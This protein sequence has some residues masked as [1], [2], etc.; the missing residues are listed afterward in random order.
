VTVVLT[1]NATSRLTSDL[2]CLAV[3]D[4]FDRVV[5]SSEIGCIKPEPE[6]FLH[7]I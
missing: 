1:T 6:Y 4:Y 3:T 5:N 2:N 7:A